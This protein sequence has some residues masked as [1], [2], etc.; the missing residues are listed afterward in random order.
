MVKGTAHIGM[1]AICTKAMVITFANFGVGQF[2]KSFR[3]KKDEQFNGLAVYGSKI[4]FS[5]FGGIV[6]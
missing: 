3:K 6:G 4:D 2:K 1:K 5:Y